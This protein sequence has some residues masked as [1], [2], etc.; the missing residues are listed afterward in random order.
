[1]P[2]CLCLAWPGDLPS[3]EAGVLEVLVLV[4]EPKAMLLDTKAGETRATA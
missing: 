1:M 3:S 2:L 4:P